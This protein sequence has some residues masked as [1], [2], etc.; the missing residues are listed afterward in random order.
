MIHRFWKWLIRSRS[1][2]RPA[3]ARLAVEALEDRSL[4]SHG[5]MLLPSGPSGTGAGDHV[6]SI[7]RGL[8]RLG[9][10]AAMA[11]SALQAPASSFVAQ[12]PWSR[13]SDPAPSAA[14]PLEA[15]LP[16][17][18]LPD[19][20]IALVPPP[21]PSRAANL[22]SL[23]SAGTQEPTASLSVAPP[24]S[25][26]A[27]RL[28]AYLTPPQRGDHD[29]A[30]LAENVPALTP[31]ALVEAPVGQSAPQ[32]G[33]LASSKWR[34][35][36]RVEPWPGEELGADGPSIGVG[37]F[38]PR[39]VEEGPQE[40]AVAG[41]ATEEEERSLLSEGP[42]RRWVVLLSVALSGGLAWQGA[43]R[44]AWPSSPAPQGRAPRPEENV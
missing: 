9:D 21:G 30:V 18:E 3:K 10:A 25:A 12:V 19:Y 28:P 20:L 17:P 43:A 6:F 38:E 22:L 37:S 5:L 34:D 24:L 27:A 44:A 1:R 33:L 32:P 35:G 31:D 42:S 39:A 4:P 40:G 26:S 2:H 29:S 14:P 23:P 7:H 36:P 16:A 11:S 41:P 13:T 15:T 8:I